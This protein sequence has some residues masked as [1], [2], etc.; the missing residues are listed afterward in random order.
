MIVAVLLGLALGSFWV[1]ELMRRNHG[2]IAPQVTKGEPD[3]IVDTFTFVRMSKTGHARY[4]I[5]G[6]KLSHYPDNDSFEIQQPRLH[7]LAQHQSP[8]SVRAERAVIEHVANKV[9]LY[10]AIKVDQPA[11]ESHPHFEL[12]TDYLLVLPDD[13]VMRTDKPVKIQL[14]LSRLA[15]VGMYTNNATREL[16]LAQSVQA[17]FQTAAR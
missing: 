15:G 6:E 14:G 7:N 11:F 8:M 4:K 10:R 12:N 13:D 3:Y 1:L 17:T 5:A 16:R 2:E 9:H